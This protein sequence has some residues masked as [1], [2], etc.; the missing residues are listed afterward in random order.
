MASKDTG[1]QGMR[2][3]M[4]VTEGFEQV[5]MTGPRDALIAEG[6]KTHVV[7]SGRGEVQGF[8]H[9]D[10][11]DKFPV[12]MTFAE[13]RADDFDAVLLPGGVINGDQIR[14]IPEAQHFVQQM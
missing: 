10:R 14:V 2:V 5:E 13:A 1:L 8:K 9:H 12:D 3:A 7:S 11:A 4:L 6:V